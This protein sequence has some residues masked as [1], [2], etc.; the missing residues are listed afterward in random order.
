VLLAH[1]PPEVLAQVLAG[2]GGSTYRIRQDLVEIR[3]CGVA[4][5]NDRNGPFSAAAPVAGPHGTVVAAVSVAVRALAEPTLLIGLVRRAVIG[6]SRELG[7]STD[8]PACAPRRPVGHRR[9]AASRSIF[10]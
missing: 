2:D 1:A 8:V 4:V 6:I 7:A 5:T 9:A 10:H 3:R